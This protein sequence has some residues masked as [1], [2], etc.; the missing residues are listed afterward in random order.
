MYN[1]IYKNHKLYK[2]QIAPQTPRSKLSKSAS[3]LNSTAAKYS[4]KFAMEPLQN[5]CCKLRRYKQTRLKQ[6]VQAEHHRKSL[7]TAKPR[8]QL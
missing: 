1:F 6:T 8:E 3:N 7:F 5:Y 2:I 4:N